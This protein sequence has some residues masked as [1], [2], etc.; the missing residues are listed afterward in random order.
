MAGASADE[1][2]VPEYQIGAPGSPSTRSLVAALAPDVIV[3]ACFPSRI[4]RRTARLARLAALNVHPSRLPNGRGPD[5]LFWTLRRGDGRAAVTVHALD[6]QLDAGPI[7]A[8][9][10]LGY[11]DGTTEA[12]LDAMLAE[13]GGAILVETAIALAAGTAVAA[14]QDEG[15]ATSHPWPGEEDYTITAD[16]SAR[17]AYNFIRGI[18]GRGVPVTITTAAER[19][20]V[21]EALCHVD[22]AAPTESGPLT[23]WVRFADGWLLVRERRDR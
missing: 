4:P 20:V 22:S 15:S 23:R 21:H 17:A 5:P 6:D 9:R 11:P 14:P 1:F 18:R 10:D 8:Q 13:A 7:F 19:I 16:G 2:H 12:D 3:V